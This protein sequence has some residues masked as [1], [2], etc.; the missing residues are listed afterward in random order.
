VSVVL[1]F[2]V[3]AFAGAAAVVALAEWRWYGEL[4]HGG[5]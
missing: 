2:L 1:A 3:G 5:E 4:R